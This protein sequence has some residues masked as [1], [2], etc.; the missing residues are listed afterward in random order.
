[1]VAFIV[2]SFAVGAQSALA[3]G[4]ITKQYNFNYTD[5]S[6]PRGSLIDI[7]GVLYGT[8]TGGGANNRGTLFAWDKVTNTITKQFSFNTS[9]GSGPSGSL[10]DISG[11]LYGTT[12]QGGANDTGNIF[13]WDPVTNAITK[14]YSDVSNPRGSLIDI[15]GVLYGTTHAGGM[16]DVGTLFALDPV[17][18]T[19]TK[20]Y[21][22]SDNP[23]GAYPQGSLVN[24]S[25]VLYGTTQYGGANDVGTLFAWDPVTNT[26][27][28]KF[29][30][31]NTDGRWPSG[32]LIN[33][34]GVLYGTTTSGGANGVGTL[35]AWDPVTNT[36]TKQYD[37]NTTDG[38]YPS[39]SLIN[40]NGVLYG[41]TQNGGVNDVGTIFSWDPVANTITKQYEFNGF[42][43]G[44]HPYGSLVNISGVF[45]GTT[46][47]G[48]AH[49]LGTVFAWDPNG[50]QTANITSGTLATQTI[51]G[52][53]AGGG[54]I[55]NSSALTVSISYTKKPNAQLHLNKG[56]ANSTISYVIGS[57]PADDSGYI[58]TY[59]NN[60]P[61]SVNNSDTIWI[62]AKTADT[63]TK[64]YYKVTVTVVAL[65]PFGTITKQYNFNYIDGENP[66]G[67]LI[68]INGV[69]YGTTYSGGANGVGTLFAWDPV[70]NTITKQYDFNGSDGENPRGSLINISGVLYGTTQQGGANSVG[71][72][73]AWDPVTNTITKQYS[74]NT[75]DGSHPRGSLINISGVLY[76]TT[77]SGGANS[78]GTLFA[79]DP[80]TNT[81][82][83]Q[84]DF[85]EIDGANPVGSLVNING[86]LYGTT[87]SY[88][89]CGGSNCVGTLFAWDPVTNTITKQYDFNGSEG[90]YPSGSLI[91]IN[92]V[93]YGTTGDGGGANGWATL[94]AWDPVTNTITKQYD[95]NYS[96]GG[97]PMESLID[98]NG[99]L[100]GTTSQGGANGNGTIFAWDPV[101]NT[102]TKQYDFNSSD[103]E[104]PR[105]SLI[106]ISGVLYGT[107]TSGGANDVGTLFAISGFVPEATC[108]D[109]ILNQDETGIDTGGS[110]TPT[111]SPTP[112]TSGS[113]AF[114]C[115]DIK[116]T[117]YQA[118]GV[119][120]PS[121]CKYAVV[122]NIKVNTNSSLG[123]KGQCSATQL[124]TQNL[125][126][127]A[128]NGKYNSYTKSTVK[129]VKILQA[130]MN[131]LGFAS[132][133]EDG[134]LGPIT[135]GAIKRMQ[136]FLG[137]KQDGLVGPNTR[138]LINTSCGVEA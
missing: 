106:N 59:T 132:G 128:R 76:G 60:I 68:D 54:S 31:N 85:N 51:A 11:V 9:D 36:I 52:D 55:A 23:D 50:I 37:F 102:I 138:G 28:K 107:T 91:D 116:A 41:T 92:G 95:F 136:K 56:T 53:F 127:G 133:K 135:D 84:Y 88:I 103:G 83:K 113:V 47:Q 17:T 32:S 13:A 72:L 39:D 21:E 73:F 4:T 80:V 131:R 26:I 34:S 7:S 89:S 124:L 104:N 45:Y 94:F 120:A 110:C 58:E 69:L 122:D 19:I 48:G 137:T 16:I 101:T 27:T 87:S 44:S 49:D 118:F 117:N 42:D 97:F 70:T 129:E 90:A 25:G 74:F 100:Y 30:F 8:T 67:S 65:T 20:Q 98:I 33:I 6:F 96:D 38:G 111:P 12:Q 134:I 18:N 114:G 3:T 81:I 24:I 22:F 14:Q 35:F 40:I 1:M 93:L 126:A 61:L 125:K 29:D 71:T 130:H 46:R 5:G 121:I 64:L 109:G 86:V 108:S 105:G 63:L 43:D 82:T 77:I 2:V 75:S 119:N 66:Y 123:T 115:K 99:V 10:I 78:V 79:W 15:S 62:L 57:Q 112:R